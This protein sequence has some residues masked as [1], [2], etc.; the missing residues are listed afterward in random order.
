MKIKI[1]QQNA[2]KI[3]EALA[4]VNGKALSFTIS[5]Y[6]AVAAYA[7]AVETMLE[8]SQ[9]PKAERNGVVAQ[10]RPSGPSASAYKYPARSTTIRLERGPKD[11]FLVGASETTVYPREAKSIAVTISPA[12]RDTIAQK[13]LAGYRMPEPAKVETAIVR[14][15]THDAI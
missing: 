13:A 10:I 8:Q 9:L 12:Q 2:T 5:S 7:A 6:S 1:A 4:A 15:S 3:Y 14:H 11:W